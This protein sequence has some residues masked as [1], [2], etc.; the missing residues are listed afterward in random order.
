MR[1]RTSQSSSSKTLSEGGKRAVPRDPDRP[2][3]GGRD[4]DC[5]ECRTGPASGTGG[6]KATRGLRG[7]GG[8]MVTRGW[9]ATMDG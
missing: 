4:R 3:R 9:T 7:A 1:D 2:H 6:Q 5:R 8:G